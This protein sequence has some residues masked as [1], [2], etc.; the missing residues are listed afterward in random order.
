MKKFY[1]LI[2]LGFILF[3]W[4]NPIF[5]QPLGE[6]KISRFWTEPACYTKLPDKDTTITVKA[7]F[8]CVGPKIS[9]C[10]DLT[11]K[12]Y[13]DSSI[14]HTVRKINLTKAV[15]DTCGPSATTCTVLIDG[16][17]MDVRIL[18]GNKI[19]I[20]KTGFISPRLT[21]D[22]KLTL[23][24]Y[25]GKTPTDKKTI[26]VKPCEQTGQAKPDLIVER[27]ELPEI[28][29]LGPDKRADIKGILVVKNAGSAPSSNCYTDIVFE[30]TKTYKKESARYP[31]PSLNPGV[32]HSITV[33][34]RLPEGN[35][36]VC[37]FLDST[38]LV[39]ESNETNNTT[40]RGFSVRSK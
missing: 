14:E 1:L 13:W 22:I 20:S 33:F 18:L 8:Q 26:I 34:I 37:A 38:N 29:T 3:L 10:Q 9:K 17:K 5:T 19:L 27:F 25:T 15:I 6:W 24:A 4:S 39:A 36:K 31:V 12:A 7:E 30:E 28:F 16:E 40:C 32:T 35:Y 2:I 23:E 11:I 21:G